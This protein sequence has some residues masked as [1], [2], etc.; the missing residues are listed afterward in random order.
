MELSI[1]NIPKT[2]TGWVQALKEACLM[3]LLFL[4]GLLVANGRMGHALLQPLAALQEKSESQTLFE[5]IDLSRESVQL[6]HFMLDT[7]F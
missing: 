6:L 1:R 5:D 2:Y 4:I 3:I 7:L